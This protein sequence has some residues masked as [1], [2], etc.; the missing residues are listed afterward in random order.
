[1][2]PLRSI[3]PVFA[4]A[5]AAAMPAAYA[6]NVSPH[7]DGQVLIWPYYTAN[8]GN[9]TLLSIVND[10]AQTKALKLRFHEG[11]NG[12]VVFAA[13]LYLGAGD[14]WTAGVFASP[15]GTAALVTDDPS[16]AVP[17]LRGD[18]ALPSLPDGRRYTPFSTADFTGARADGGPATVARTR[19]GHI[20]IIEMGKLSGASAQAAQMR[21]DATPRPHDCAR[22]VDAWKPG[23]Y[24]S[25]NPAAE[26]AAPAGGLVGNATIVNAA[27]GSVLA[28]AATALDGF[29]VRSRHTG[30]GDAHPNLADAVTDENTGVASAFVSFGTRTV[31]ADYP[32]SRAIDAVSAVLATPYTMGETIDASDGSAAT[33]W[34]MT[35][36]TKRFYVDPALGSAVLGQAPFN[37]RFGE[38]RPGQ[39]CRVN[40]TGYVPAAYDR[41]AQPLGGF[42]EPPPTPMLCF[43]TT[44]LT[45]TSPAP[46][47]TPVLGASNANGEAAFDEGYLRLLWRGA[48]LA[49]AIGG[50]V[51]AG[52]PVIGVQATNWFNG[53]IVPGVRANYALALPL[54]GTSECIDGDPGCW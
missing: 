32:A 52:L 54:R 46:V 29:S 13:N 53:N 51:F 41:D 15:D 16:C 10:S 45:T 44:V 24:W 22:L 26:V 28:I 21:Y 38:P 34:V 6:V 23:G 18:P 48:A 49:P 17:D 8:A 25:A 7:G 12:R 11:V 37:Q 14:M 19:E 47:P 36:P 3:R 42:P 40:G 4:A 9:S 50:Q 2:T 1:V 27:R 31:R 35:A 5:L 43:D 33:E 39:A 30:P 20:E